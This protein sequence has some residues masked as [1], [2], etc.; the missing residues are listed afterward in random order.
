MATLPGEVRITW[1][2]PGPWTQQRLMWLCRVWLMKNKS[3]ERHTCL[4]LR[5]CDS[6]PRR[7]VSVPEE[8]W[9]IESGSGVGRGGCCQS[10]KPRLRTEMLAVFPLWLHGHRAG[11]DIGIRTRRS[12]WNLGQP[13]LR[14]SKQEISS[15]EQIFYH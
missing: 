4:C 9:L 14:T 5:H 10:N 8:A 2:I 6:Q 12:R 1:Y 11:K 15:S 13:C 7:A 3:V